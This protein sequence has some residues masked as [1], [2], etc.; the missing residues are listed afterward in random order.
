MQDAVGGE[1]RDLRF[2]WPPPA[3]RLAL[4]LRR[5]DHNVAKR[6]HAIG[7]GAQPSRR[8]ATANARWQVVAE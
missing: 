3:A 4:R 5:A 7:A 8:I 2:E 1:E 6:D